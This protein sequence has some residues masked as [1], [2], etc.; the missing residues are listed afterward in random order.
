MNYTHDY[1][2]VNSRTVL[3]TPQTYSTDLVRQQTYDTYNAPVSFC[4]PPKTVNGDVQSKAQPS[5]AFI[6]T[7]TFKLNPTV[8][9]F[10]PSNFQNQ[11][12]A[13]DST[14]ISAAEP[15]ENVCKA[16]ENEVASDIEDNT[17]EEAEE[18]SPEVEV[19]AQKIKQNGVG[20]KQEDNSQADE[21]KPAQEPVKSEPIST[22]PSATRSWADIVSRGQSSGKTQLATNKPVIANGNK[23]VKVSIKA[24][25]QDNLSVEEDKLALV[26]GSKFFYINRCFY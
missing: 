26:L 22:I 1:S 12:A 25:E 21:T 9:C 11:I 14:D 23:E 16:D 13:S 5:Q 8:S 19:S 17:N 3:Q 20:Q 6:S 10:V 18:S 15:K 4:E 2:A 7:S 24:P